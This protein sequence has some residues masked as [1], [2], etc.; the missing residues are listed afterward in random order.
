MPMNRRYNSMCLHKKDIFQ[1]PKEDA[2]APKIDVY[3][4]KRKEKSCLVYAVQ[5][6]STM[7]KTKMSITQLL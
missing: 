3:W 1:H 2:S 6:S 5:C 4:E 7:H